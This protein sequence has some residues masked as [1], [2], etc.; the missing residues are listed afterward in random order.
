M[1]LA[2]DEMRQITVPTLVVW[3][4]QDRVFSPD[5]ATR[6]AGDIDGSTVK[7][8]DGSG[9]LPQLEQTDAFLQAVIPFLENIGE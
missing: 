3:G 9:H 2:E 7:M 1:T 6:L 5:N 4:A 8:I